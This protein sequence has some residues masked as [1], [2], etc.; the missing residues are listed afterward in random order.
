VPFTGATIHFTG[1]GLDI[2]TTSGAGFRATGGGTVNVS[3]SNNSLRK[4][5]AEGLARYDR[6]TPRLLLERRNAGEALTRLR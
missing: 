5:L 2:D 4:R 1:G 3:E 6:S